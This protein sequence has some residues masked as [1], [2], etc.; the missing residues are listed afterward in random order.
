MHLLS[1]L[2]NS[3]T[4]VPQTWCAMSQD[5][6]FF[7]SLLCRSPTQGHIRFDH[8]RCTERKIQ[9]DT[10]FARS[11][12]VCSTSQ[13]LIRRISASVD[14]W[15]AC[16]AA[17]LTEKVK[18][19]TAVSGKEKCSLSHTRHAHVISVTDSSCNNPWPAIPRHSPC[20]SCGCGVG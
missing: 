10:F 7:S 12:A 14:I 9:T 18:T 15:G 6:F 19:E 11:K 4:P 13:R 3:Q 2:S 8:A 16:E 5:F 17:V 1:L 20:F